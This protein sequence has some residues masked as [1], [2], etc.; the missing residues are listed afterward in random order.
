MFRYE[1]PQKGR[2]RQFYQFGVELLGVEKPQADIEVIALGWQVLGALGLMNNITLEINTIG[3]PES[4]QQYRAALVDYLRDFKNEL[5]AD[6]QV[7]L[8]K[9]PLRILDSKEETDKRILEKAPAMADFLNNASKEFFSQVCDGLKSLGLAYT[10]SPRL[11]RGL[12]Y[13]CHTVFEFTTNTLGSQNA[14]LS[15]GR[16]DGLIQSMGGPATHGVGWAA[17]TDRLAMMLSE[18]PASAKPIAIVPAGPEAEAFAL[19]LT[20]TLRSQ[21]I[22]ADIGY[23]GNIGKR[24]KRADKIGARAALIIG[25]N[26]LA[27]QTVTLKDLQTGEQKELPVSGLEHALRALV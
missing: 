8:E 21:G 15:G 13:Y 20:Q 27:R 18:V 16:Y 26:E 10:L 11:V 23:S 22:S 5:S 6:S 12:D 19:K 25:S 24:L 9:N 4:R 7:R 2:Y 14:V 1:R 3:D 17:G